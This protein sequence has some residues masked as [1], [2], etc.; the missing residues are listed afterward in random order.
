[1][2]TVITIMNIRNQDIWILWKLIINC[3]KNNQGLEVFFFVNMDDY[4]YIQVNNSS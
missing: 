3:T 1:M 2:K 4:I